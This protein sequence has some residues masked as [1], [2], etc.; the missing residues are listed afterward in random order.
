M[1]VHV[2]R[3]VAGDVGRYTLPRTM[4]YILVAG[5]SWALWTP[6][7]IASPVAW[8]LMAIASSWLSWLGAFYLLIQHDAAHT[9]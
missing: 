6:L 9:V 8:S 2:V 3:L 7:H 5:N 1:W 4:F